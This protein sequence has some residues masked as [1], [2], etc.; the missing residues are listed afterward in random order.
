MIFFKG[1]AVIYD[2]KNFII[3]PNCRRL[4]G[5]ELEPSS[6]LVHAVLQ[7]V[8]AR[9]LHYDE[10]LKLIRHEILYLL[11]IKEKKL[12]FLF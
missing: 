6:S 3:A 1:M 2:I 7:D 4:D 10:S 8:W 12:L 11:Y 9:T 5:P